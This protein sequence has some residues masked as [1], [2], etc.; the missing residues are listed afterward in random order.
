MLTYR[1]SIDYG[2]FSML[3]KAASSVL[4]AVLALA[5]AASLSL[6]IGALPAAANSAAQSFPEVADLKW[7]VLALSV[8][9][10]VCFEF[11]LACAW[12]LLCAVEADRIFSSASARWVDGIAWAVAVACL[13]T[14]AFLLLDVLT[15]IGP[16]SVPLAAL[17]VLVLSLGV[18]AAVVVVRVVLHN[19]TQLQSDMS[20]VI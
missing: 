7:P 8:A 13:L 15:G 6:Q 11:A 9:W 3:T 17:G 1:S 4:K 2:W 5:F 18:L 10:L 20:E 14:A 16:I 19:A 12:R